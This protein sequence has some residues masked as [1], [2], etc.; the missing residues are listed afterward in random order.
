MARTHSVDK[1]PTDMRSGMV[2]Q[3]IEFMFEPLDPRV[4]L[5]VMT[6]FITFLIVVKKKSTAGASGL[7]LLFSTS[8]MVFDLMFKAMLL[9]TKTELLSTMT[10]E[11]TR[12]FASETPRLLK[13]LFAEMRSIIFA[14]LADPARS[15]GSS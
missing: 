1:R 5:M 12:Q 11:R 15:Q 4:Y 14:S 2:H 6:Q 9:S 8:W 10:T 3:F 13:R 7:S